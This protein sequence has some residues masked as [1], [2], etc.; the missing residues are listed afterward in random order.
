[1]TFKPMSDRVLIQ[2][3][4]TEQ[5]TT[6]GIVLPDSANEK[7]ASGTVLA[8]GPGKYNSD[9]QLSA[10]QVSVGDS[11]VFGKFAGHDMKING[12][13]ITVIHEDDILAIIN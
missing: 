5:T 3:D 1:M 4:D 2:R 12:V 11:V 13:E 9:G 6:G 8:V 7:P 10:M